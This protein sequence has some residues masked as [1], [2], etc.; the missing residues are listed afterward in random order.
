MQNIPVKTI[1][2]FLNNYL[3]TDDFNDYCKNGLQI[4]GN[5]VSNGIIAGVSA[6]LPLI[7]HAIEKNINTILVHHGLIWKNTNL[8]EIRDPLRKRLKAI[9]END[10]NL[11][12]YHLPLDAHPKIGNNIS[13]I[14]LLGIPHK[15]IPFDAGYMAVFKIPFSINDIEDIFN[16]NDIHFQFHGPREKPISRILAVS[17]GSSS[18]YEKLDREDCDLFI[19]GEIRESIYS[20]IKETGIGYIIMGH[21][22]SEIFG[23]RNLSS[24]LGSEFGIYTE[25]KNIPNP[26]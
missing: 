6:N 11:I 14:R 15:I 2:S 16:S 18:L 22:N 21:Y 8:L 12:G 26:Y 24:L 1:I 13:I 23:I 20:L 10:I 19:S 4:Y 25:F 9:L 5:P 7:H 3:N 17:G